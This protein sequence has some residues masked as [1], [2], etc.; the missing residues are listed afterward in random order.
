MLHDPLNGWVVLGV[1]AAF[2][3]RRMQFA[4]LKQLHAN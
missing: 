4:P 3:G 1:E 2:R